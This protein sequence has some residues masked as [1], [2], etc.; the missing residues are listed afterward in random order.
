MVAWVSAL[1][2]PHRESPS[3]VLSWHHLEGMVFCHPST[4]TLYIS[5]QTKDTAHEERILWV[6]QC[7]D[8][9]WELLTPYL[10]LAG[11]ERNLPLACDSL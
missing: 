4:T 8:L 5:S 9:R 3:R 2:Q 11:Y 1:L 6:T 7:W 10:S